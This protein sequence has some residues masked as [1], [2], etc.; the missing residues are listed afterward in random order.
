MP[1]D[2]AVVCESKRLVDELKWALRRTNIGIPAAVKSRFAS[3]SAM[4]TILKGNVAVVAMVLTPS[5][6]FE[7]PVSLLPVLAEVPKE[8]LAKTDRLRG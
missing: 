6:E 3:S 5:A 4:P 1:V 2:V 8:A 7:T